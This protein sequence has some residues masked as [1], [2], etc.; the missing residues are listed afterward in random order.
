[1]HS[2]CNSTVL[3]FNSAV[4]VTCLFPGKRMQRLLQFRRHGLPTAA[5]RLAC[6]GH[7][8]RAH[9]ACLSR[10]SGAVVMKCTLV[11]CTVLCNSGMQTFHA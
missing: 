3:L 6:A 8:D 4:L 5:G 9:R 11:E 7:V 10:K 1:M 2:W